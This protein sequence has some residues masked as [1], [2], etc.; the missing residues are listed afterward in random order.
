MTV[1]AGYADWLKTDARYVTY[2]VA[3]A[4]AAWGDNAVDSKVIS[5]LALKADA[6]TEVAAQAAFLTGPLARDRHVVQGLRKD[7]IG[8]LVTLVN[9]QLGY[10]SGALAF[11]LGAQEGDATTTLFV[12]KRMA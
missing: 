4:A 10:A 8:Q 3:G 9:S 5:P 11:V 12:L 6:T 7:L 1:D 2:T